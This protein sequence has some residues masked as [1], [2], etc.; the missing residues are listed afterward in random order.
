MLSSWC[1]T[2]Q[3]RLFREGCPPELVPPAAANE[4]ASLWAGTVV[5]RTN[6]IELL[7]GAA[8]LQDPASG[9]ATTEATITPWL[10]RVG[11]TSW[12]VSFQVSAGATAMTAIARVS[13]VMINVDPENLEAA[14]PIP[15]HLV[16]PMTALAEASSA[17]A[18]RAGL[19]G[20]D[21]ALLPEGV[22]AD[23]AP[24]GAFVWS[25]TVRA[26]DCDSLGHI[27]N[28]LYIRLAAE[29]RAVA[30]HELPAGEALAGPLATAA[31]RVFVVDY[32]GQPQC[33]AP[34]A[35]IALPSTQPNRRP[36]DPTHHRPAPAPRPLLCSPTLRADRSI[37]SRWS[38]G[39]RTPPWRASRASVTKCGS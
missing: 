21:E 27:N 1:D 25:S 12:G 23:G 28:A 33:A 9:T 16:D 34:S 24:E 36:A 11:R 19:A 35:T 7:V 14:A 38:P 15:A 31:P 3:G 37:E 13:T 32:L 4:L 20:P 26:T 30:E 10:S 22:G 29:A 5:M 39:R 6:T 17:A 8:G 18:E 2:N